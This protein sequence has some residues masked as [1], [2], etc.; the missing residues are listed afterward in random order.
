MIYITIIEKDLADPLQITKDVERSL[1]YYPQGNNISP[2]F[3]D[4]CT[5][6]LLVLGKKLAIPAAE[7]VALFFIRDAMLDSFDPISK[8]LQLMSSLIEYEDPGLTLFLEKANIM[9]YYA[10]SWL[11]TWFSHDFENYEKVIRLFDVFISSQ[12]MMPVYIASAVTLLRRNEILAADKDLVHSLITRIPQDMDIEE[13][14]AKA[15]ELESKYSILQ[16]QKQSGI[17]LHDESVINTWKKDWEK[18]KW[19]Q[20]PDQLQA[21]RYLSHQIEKE[22]W[23]D[24]MSLEWTRRRR[25]TIIEDE[26]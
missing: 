21:N 10:L 8:Q 2:G 11:L 24:E 26:I 6:F 13:I 17:W 22:E 14:I 7:N 16:L 12:A 18:L 19:G 23:E 25:M 4:I 9:P 15:I 20:V 5:C 3:H 1:Y